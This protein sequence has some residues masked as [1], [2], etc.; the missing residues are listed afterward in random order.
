VEIQN[1]FSTRQLR[2]YSSDDVVGVELAGALKN[3]MALAAGIS[4]GMALGFN[5]K[6][7]LLT[8]GIAE[9]SRIGTALGGNR[10]T[11]SG[12][13][14][15]GDLITTCTSPLSRNRFVGEQIGQGRALDDVLAGMVMVAEGVWTAR[16]ASELAR[17]HGIEMPITDAVC[18]IID[19]RIDPRAALIELMVRNLKAED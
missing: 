13:S 16:A 2:L 14:G 17:R 8:R 6:G 11:F 10:Q 18:R 12:L 7:A 3:V 15:M 5:T 4:D 1:R 9:I 19:D